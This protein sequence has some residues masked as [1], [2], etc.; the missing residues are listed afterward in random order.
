MDSQMG[1]FL[2]N[3]ILFLIPVLIVTGFFMFFY[4]VGIGSG[5]FA[6]IEKNID[7]QRSNHKAL[8]GLGYNENTPYYKMLNADYYKA[9]VLVLGTSR[10]MQIR[11]LYFTGS[12]YNCGGAVHGNY[13]EYKNYLMNL[14][15]KPELLILCLDSWAFND[16]WNKDE[17]DY[18]EYTPIEKENR[19]KI[20]MAKQIMLDLFDGK[21]TP[22]SLKEYPDNIGFNGKIKDDGFRYDGS[23]RYGYAG[24]DITKSSD[25]GFVNTYDRIDKGVVR[26]EY[27]DK[28]DDD[29]LVQLEE[30]LSYCKSENMN[31]LAYQAP[32]APSVIDRMNA[33]GNYG[34]IEEIT[35]VCERLFDKYGYEYFDYV[36]V[37]GIGIDDSYFVDG[38]HGGEVAYAM[39]IKNMVEQNSIIS[40]Y[41]DTNKLE[42]CI[43]NRY[44]NVL[45]EVPL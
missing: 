5:E 20:V 27:G 26:F 45:I 35:P 12:F 44:N 15:Y 7:K 34:Y 1:K 29:T 31:V 42:E 10:S 19:E 4:F 39:L 32:F 17:A 28:I 38:F 33:S 41:V 43:N 24:R 6:D 36:S 13:R 21:W 40:N 3:L 22:K 16:N 18:L 14:S 11:D 25:Y 30:L 9:D 23:Y 2:K 8:I 37:S